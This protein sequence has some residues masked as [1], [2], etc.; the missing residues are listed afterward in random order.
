MFLKN[1]IEDIQDVVGL[2]ANFRKYK[3]FR[4]VNIWKNTFLLWTPKSLSLHHLVPLQEA[5]IVTPFL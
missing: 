1:A 3:M 2:H 5:I 4:R